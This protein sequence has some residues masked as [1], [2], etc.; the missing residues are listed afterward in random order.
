[1]IMKKFSIFNFFCSK[2]LFVIFD[3]Y[4]SL[5]YP[6]PPSNYSSVFVIMSA[7]AYPQILPK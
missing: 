5:A 6:K 3:S 7:F 4:A 1:M 2:V